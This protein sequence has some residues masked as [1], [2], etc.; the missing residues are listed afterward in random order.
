MADKVVDDLSPLS[1]REED[2]TAA[3]KIVAELDKLHAAAMGDATAVAP[4]PPAAASG[5]GAA[6][7]AAGAAVEPSLL[8][9]WGQ[10][11]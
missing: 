10:A 3:K 8:D 11:F 7:P 5:G 6:T 4:V 9:F 1:L 2:T